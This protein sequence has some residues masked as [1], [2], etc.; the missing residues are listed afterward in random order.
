MK[1]PQREYAYR[2]EKGTP[3]LHNHRANPVGSL[4]IC[5]EY[6]EY[7]QEK[8]ADCE[9]TMQQ[10]QH[11]EPAIRLIPNNDCQPRK[12]RGHRH[13]AVTKQIEVEHHAKLALVQQ[14]QRNARQRRVSNR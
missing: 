1:I 12:E 7:W 11:P 14:L 9:Y 5:M 4:H 2:Q 10:Q 6:S 3:E 8:A 13:K